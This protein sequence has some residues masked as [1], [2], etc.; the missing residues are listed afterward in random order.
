MVRLWNGGGRSH[1]AWQSDSTEQVTTQVARTGR[2]TSQLPR[3]YSV[4]AC[5]EQLHSK[6]LSLTSALQ[7]ATL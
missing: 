4:P 3:K 5:R 7:Q 1:L 6:L 2:V